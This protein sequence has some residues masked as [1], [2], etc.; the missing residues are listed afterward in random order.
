MYN[1]FKNLFYDDSGDKRT[2][3]EYFDKALAEYEG[4]SVPELQDID[5]QSG[6][7]VGDI[8]TP[9]MGT[10]QYERI[11]LDPETR[12]AQKRQMAA[13]DELAAGG[14]LNLADKANLQRISNEE[15][16]RE[17][18]QR[19][20]ILD[21]YRKRGMGGAGTELA[22]LL[23]AQQEGAN[24]QSQRDLDVAGMAQNRALEAGGRSAD[25]ASRLRGS[26]FQEQAR[27]SEA[28]DAAAKFNA[29]MLSNTNQFNAANLQRQRNLQADAANEQEMYNKAKK[30]LNQF[31][32]EHKKRAGTSNIYTERGQQV[33]QD[34]AA[35]KRQQGE[36][37]GGVANIGAGIAAGP[38]GASLMAGVTKGAAEGAGR[39]A[40]SYFSSPN[41]YVETR[42]N[43][44][45][46][47][48]DE[49]LKYYGGF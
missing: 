9:T 45:R 29:S 25:I 30:P 47:N 34:M 6:E 11:Q 19:E 49:A 18:G 5:L 37:W 28:M 39:G 20:A 10:S 3:D 12:M 2:R 15:A 44:K 21:Q 27:K 43:Q 46:D 31:D 4:L 40:G 36:L 16:Q 48:Y 26:D 42:E 7:Y 35:N 1:P 33:G 22:A 41:N 17:R 24:R 23:S 38:V 13:L 14:G 8:E 32:M